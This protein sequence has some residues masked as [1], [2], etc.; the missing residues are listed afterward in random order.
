MVSKLLA[1]EAYPKLKD[2]DFRLLRAVELNMRHHKW[3]PLEDIARFA[4]MDLESA[5]YRL[6]KLDKLG[7][8]IR[9]SDIG[10]I[11]YQLTI[12]GYDAL[13][14][15]AFAKKGVIEAISSTH[16]GV[17]K[18]ADVYVAITPQGEKVAIKF[19]R[20]GERTSA[21]KAYY[22]SDVFADKHHKSWLYVSRL[23]AK[24]E[25]EALVLLSSFAKVPKPIAWNRHAIVM[26]FIDGVELAELRDTDLTK[27]EAEE[28]LGKVLDEYEKIV[29]FGIV[30]G[31]MSE[32]NIVI[33][34]DND[35]LIID[36]AQYLTCANP[37][38]LGL[39]KRDISV[40]LNAF[41]RRWGVKRDFEEEWKRFYE[42]WQIGR[43]EKEES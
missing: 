27:E 26:E 41:R 30:H 37:E 22:H 15:R 10:Y 11:G 1:L 9:R 12:H 33:T 13:A 34:K 38:S 28:I 21:R 42:A 25:H 20:I 2:I 29:K 4:R 31:D 7:L 5:S 14:I 8:V 16:I 3:V 43:R 23:I 6:G 17:G 18:D 35:I 24:K 39:L 40:L 36:W 19:N 32:F